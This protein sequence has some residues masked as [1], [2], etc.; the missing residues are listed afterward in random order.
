MKYLPQSFRESQSEWFGKQGLSWHVSCAFFPEKEK[1]SDGEKTFEIM[2]YVHLVKNDTQ[3]WLTI[4]HILHHTR[5]MLK[6]Q[7]QI[8]VKS[9]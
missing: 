3:G 6:E 4:S 5:C 2:S 8:L 9:P 1:E 7:N